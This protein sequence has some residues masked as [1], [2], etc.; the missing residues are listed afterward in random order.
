MG[1]LLDWDNARRERE[2]ASTAALID[3]E[4][5]FRTASHSEPGEPR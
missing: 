3:A 4:L 1:A 2:I 5:A